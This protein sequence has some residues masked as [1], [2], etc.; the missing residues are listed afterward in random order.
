MARTDLTRLQ[1]SLPRSS[2]EQL[3]KLARS[4]GMSRSKIVAAAVAAF[5]QSKGADEVE[6]RF[7]YRLDR[8]S[9][10]L[11]RIERNTHIE[12]ESV[13]LFARYML[14]VIAPVAEDDDA[15]RAIGRERFTAFVSRVGQQLASGR[16]TFNDEDEK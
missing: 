12:I 7:A 3:E 1:I 2:I 8:M 6:R 9:N 14:T 4:P 10:Q 13:A 5:I 11:S 16:R 15:A